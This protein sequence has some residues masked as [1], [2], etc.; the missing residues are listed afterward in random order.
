MIELEPKDA[1]RVA[2]VGATGAV[3]REMISILQSRGFPVESLHPFASARSV[4]EDVEWD[5][6]TVKVVELTPESLAAAR[7]DIALFSAGGQ[8]SR[9]FAPVAVESGAVVVDN[10]SAFRMDPAVPLVVP[11]VNP[12]QLADHR[13]RGIVANPNCSTI[14]LVMVLKPILDAAGLRR[15]VV[16]TYQSVSGAGQGGMEELSAQVVALFNQRELKRSRFPHQ[17]AF[18]CIPQIGAFRDDGYSEEEWKLVAE[19][20]RILDLPDLPVSPTAVRVPVFACHAEAVN[21]ETLEPL[22]LDEVRRI[23]SEAP[24]VKVLDDAPRSIYPMNFPLAGTD[25]V[26]VGRLRADVGVEDAFNCWI[27]ADNLR[28]G[29]ALNAVQIAEVLVREYA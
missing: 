21:V 6:R 4:G 18:N 5:G 19:T 8:V 3:G 13:I 14:Q 7:C 27:V 16:S 26:H 23:L 10:S 25:D 24:G 12:E 15:V 28:K 2:V 1:Y 20:R 11:E 17:I 29:A 22:G 9:E